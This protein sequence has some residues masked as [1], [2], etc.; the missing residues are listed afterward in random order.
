MT[1]RNFCMVKSSAITAF[2]LSMLVLIGC[3]TTD[4][5]R[6]IAINEVQSVVQL[7]SVAP[8]VSEGESAN[9]H[10]VCVSSQ[11]GAE[12][13]FNNTLQEYNT[14]LNKY[15]QTADTTLLPR[16]N[17]LQNTLQTISDNPA[18]SFVITSTPSATSG[19]NPSLSTCG[20]D[21]GS[22]C[23]CAPGCSCLSGDVGC[24]CNCPNPT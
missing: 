13:M 7:R 16:L 11:A 2:Y 15:T 5:P 3:G 1:I 21:H 17:Y 4:D 20:D 8:G 6:S 24:G 14:L 18:K 22:S 19:V 9:Q 12:W 23:K 10:M